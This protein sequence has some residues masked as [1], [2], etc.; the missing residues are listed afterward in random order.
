MNGDGLTGSLTM[1]DCTITDNSADEVGGGMVLFDV[2][3]VSIAGSSIH[4]N[5]GLD[6]AG[7]GVAGSQV[8][9]TDTAVV[10]NTAMGTGGGMLLQ[11][12]TGVITVIIGDWGT[13]ADDN[14]PQ[15]VVVPGVGSFSGYGAAA[16]FE[17]DAT[18]CS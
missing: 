11:P 4:D 2:P 13:G 12:G 6:G 3:Q 10:R 7:L 14:A 9:L 8:T 1:T 5:T 18:G 16:S 15:D 17:C